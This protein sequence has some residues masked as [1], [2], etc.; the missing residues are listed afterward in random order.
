MEKEQKRLS[1]YQSSQ[2]FTQS[3]FASAG[4]EKY[5]R[6]TD[7]PAKDQNGNHLRQT[8]P[9]AS[10]T[11]DRKYVVDRARPKTD[12]EYDPCSNFS[13]D[14][15]SGSSVDCK[16]RS[17]NKVH[18]NETEKN[19]QP[20][21]LDDSDDEGT[22]VIDIP[23]SKKH[24]GRRRPKPKNKTTVTEP[25]HSPVGKVRPEKKKLG[26]EGSPIHNVDVLDKGR[27]S[28]K[29][30]T[31]TEEQESSEG[32]LIID[33]SPLEDEKKCGTV[34]KETLE[35]PKLCSIIN[36]PSA[37]G[38]ETKEGPTNKRVTI[39]QHLRKETTQ[40]PASEPI[41]E[42][43]VSP[44]SKMET[45]D[46]QGEEKAQNIENVLD[47][48]STCLDNLRNESEKIISIQ[49]VTLLPVCSV[50]NGDI[51]TFGTESHTDNKSECGPKPISIK[52]VSQDQGSLF[53]QY[54]PIVSSQSFASSLRKDEEHT[55]D[56]N[57][58]NLVETPWP[59]VQESSKREPFV[60]KIPYVSG[61]DDESEPSTSQLTAGRSVECE[62]KISDTF[63][64]NE[65]TVS[66]QAFASAAI[67]RANNEIIEIDSSSEDD[68]RYSDLDLSETDPMEECYRIFMEAN[69]P[70]AAVVKNEALTVP[71]E[72]PMILSDAPVS[73]VIKNIF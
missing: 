19:V 71:P 59:N 2:S 44:Q 72:A 45:L 58:Q 17:T 35:S 23:L 29:P 50:P 70:E 13:A 38:K 22:L 54:F 34:T 47:D 8:K 16:L 65:A 24:Q 36:A 4:S 40:E 1:Q 37:E 3:E 60:H 55:C 7:S 64:P 20:N 41:A 27:A 12:L 9:V 51:S 31:V 52:K 18:N 56:P 68:L 53:E 63:V 21:N 48:I 25:Q 43:N 33:V 15:L 26:S 14:L 28:V 32:E 46:T 67:E 10:S 69:Q 30:P 39:V 6:T 11:A 66:L 57:S 42:L 49:D 61:I 73:T 5:L 62:H